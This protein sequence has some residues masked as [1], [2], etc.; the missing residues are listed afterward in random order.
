MPRRL[1]LQTLT[2]S[3][4]SNRIQT[5]FQHATNA[6]Q[7]ILYRTGAGTRRLAGMRRDIAPKRS[8]G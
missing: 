7:H 2:I 4:Y 5:V 6:A 3:G 8:D 1:L